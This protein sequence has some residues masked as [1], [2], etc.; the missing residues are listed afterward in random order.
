[1]PVWTVYHRF[2]SSSLVVSTTHNGRIPQNQ[3]KTEIYN[4]R[5]L[6]TIFIRFQI[7]VAY[8]FQHRVPQLT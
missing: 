1:M 5:K 8:V 2:Y 4:M 7:N 6:P 3:R